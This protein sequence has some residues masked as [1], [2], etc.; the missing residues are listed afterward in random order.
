MQVTVQKR[1]L[2]SLVVRHIHAAQ[3]PHML[4]PA[5]AIRKSTMRV[6]NGAWLF[7]HSLRQH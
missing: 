2:S 5:S 1:K 6:I 7:E 4:R 3:N